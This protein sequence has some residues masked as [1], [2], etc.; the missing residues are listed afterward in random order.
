MCPNCPVVSRFFGLTLLRIVFA[1]DGEATHLLA[2]VSLRTMFICLILLHGMPTDIPLA[3]EGGKT[4]AIAFVD[5]SVDILT[6]TTFLI[7]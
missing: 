6:F 2:S 3:S 5:A 1:I 7:L 4:V